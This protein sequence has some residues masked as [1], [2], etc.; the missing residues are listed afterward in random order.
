[1]TKTLNNKLVAS[2][3]VGFS[4]SQIAAA[5][6]STATADGTGTGQIADTTVVVQPVGVDSQA[7]YK[8]TLPTTTQ[9][10]K[11]ILFLPTLYP[12]HIVTDEALTKLNGLPT[13][14]SVGDMTVGSM[15]AVEMVCVADAA[16]IITLGVGALA[17]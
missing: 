8:I 4:S 2:R 17:T 7:G 15:V 6:S 1:M 3:K 9:I 16:W 10:G 12:Y 5:V 11:R 14:A 13:G